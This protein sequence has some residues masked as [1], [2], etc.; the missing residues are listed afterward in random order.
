MNRSHCEEARASMGS[1]MEPEFELTDE[2]WRL[3]SDLFP[4]KPRSPQGGRPP[5]C[6]RLC[7]EAI[8]WLLRSGARWKDIPSHLPSPSTCWRRFKEWTESGI[9]TKAWRRLLGKLRRDGQVDFSETIA[10]GT[11]SPAKKGANA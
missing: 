6:P 3:I 2:Q 8:V 10:D 5:Q 11:F 9:W 4:D 7:F 1:R